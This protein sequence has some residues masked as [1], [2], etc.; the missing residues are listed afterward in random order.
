MCFSC[1][2]INGEE[3]S[4]QKLS[5]NAGVFCLQKRKGK[6]MKNANQKMQK[7]FPMPNSIFRIGLCGGE[8]LV[9][10]Y[11]LYCEDRRTY[12]C[13]PSYATIGEAVGMSRN[14]VK[15]YVDML[16]RKGLIS[17]QY[18]SILTHDGRIHN[19]SLLYTLKPIEPVEE[20]YFR[21]M[22]EFQRARKAVSDA[23]KGAEK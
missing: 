6:K 22:L 15:K 19:G 21:K 17:T 20:E 10:A 11:L 4:S 1:R 5:L 8:I 13:H 18:T 12:Q 23:Q 2:V 7:F 14:T 16:E 9:Y 3:K